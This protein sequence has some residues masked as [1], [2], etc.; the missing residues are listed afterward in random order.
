MDKKQKKVLLIGNGFLSKK[1]SAF[2]NEKKI[3]N[4]YCKKNGYFS[5]SDL[6]RKI[7]NN[8]NFAI[9]LFGKTSIKF[10]EKYKK[11]SFKINVKKTSDVIEVLKKKNVK[12]LF[13]SSDLVFS[14]KKKI[15]YYNSKQDNKLQYG[16][17]KTIIEN[18]YKGNKNFCILR[19]SKIIDA[20]PKFFVTD[21]KKKYDKKICAPIFASDVCSIIYKIINNF[22]PGIFQYSTSPL[23][24]NDILIKNSI[25]KRKILFPKMYNNVFKIYKLT[26]EKTSSKEVLKKIKKYGL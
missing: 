24:F 16:L 1:I 23:V 9:I 11:E 10:C 17:Q 7:K 5:I 13:I 18:K 26:N 19:I 14:G 2:L 3:F 12:I 8:Y 21:Q 15:Y 4:N 20:S 22:Q 6:K 25:K